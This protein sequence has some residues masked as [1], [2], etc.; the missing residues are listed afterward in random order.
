VHVRRWTTGL[1]AAGVTTA[2]LAG[3]SP[4]QAVQVA[5]KD[6]HPA[7]P[8]PVAPAKGSAPEQAPPFDDGGTSAAPTGPSVSVPV[9]GT[10][11]TTVLSGA[12]TQVGDLPV[13]VKGVKGSP[14]RVRVTLST[15]PDV[16]AQGGGAAVLVERLDGSRAPAPV[17]VALDASALGE[18]FHGNWVHRLRGQVV[19]ACVALTHPHA[20]HGKHKGHAYAYGL[21]RRCPDAQGVPPEPVPVTDD[22]GDGTVVFDMTA[23][24]EVTEEVQDPS[25]SPDPTASPDPSPTAPPTQAPSPFRAQARSVL[26]QAATATAPVTAM[27]LTSGASGSTGSFEATP[28][29]SSSHWQVGVQSGD[30]STSYS[31]PVPAAPAGSAPSLA[32]TYSSQSVDGRTSASNTQASWVGMGWDLDPGSVQRRYVPC[33]TSAHPGDLCWKS[34]N[35]V[36]SLGGSS[37][38]LYKGT[39]GRWHGASDSGWRV[40]ELTGAPNGTDT[41]QYWRVTDT[42]GTQYWFGYGQQPTTGRATGS[43]WT[44][45]VY[46]LHTGDPCH[47][48]SGSRCTQA[49][50]WNLDRVVDVHGNVTTYFWSPERNNYGRD[51]STTRLASYTRGGTLARV[52]YGQLAGHENVGAPAR[53][54]FSTAYR[55]DGL[56]VCPAPNEDNGK[57]FPD[58]PNDLLCPVDSRCTHHSP[59]FFDTRRLDKVTT[60][61]NARTAWRPVDEIALTHTFPATADTSDRTLFLSAIRR[62][63]IR[64]TTRTSLPPVR[65]SGIRLANRV[66]YQAAGVL[67]LNMWR[68]NRVLSEMGAL[69]MVSYGRPN[70][71]T[72]TALPKPAYNTSD[73][74]PQYWVPADNPRWAGFGWFHKYLVTKVVVRDQTGHAPDQVTAYLYGGHAAW[75]H[76]IDLFTPKSQQS[77]GQWRGYGVTTVT[78]GTAV[79][80]VSRSLWF[81]GMNGDPLPGSGTR[82]VSVTDSTGAAVTDGNWLAGQVRETRQLTPG[83]TELAGSVQSYFTKQTVVGTGFF[84]A[85]AVLPSRADT[86]TRIT[87]PLTG[88]LLPTRKTR[89]QVT[90]DPTYLQPTSALDQGDLATTTDDVCTSTT[91]VRNTTKWLLDTPSVVVTHPSTCASTTVLGKSEHLYD[92]Q[93]LGYAPKVGNETTTYVLVTA[94]HLARTDATYDGRGRVLSSTDANRHTSHITFTE[95]YPHGPVTTVTST[96]AKGFVR[97]SALD[98]WRQTPVTSTDQNGRSTTVRY[99]ALGRLVRVF[100]PGDSTSAT[101][102]GSRAIAYA[103]SQTSP[104]VVVTDVRQD[105]DTWVRGAAYVDSLGR[106][107]ETASPADGGRTFVY[108]RYDDRG[109]VAAVTNPLFST[110]DL[111]PGAL[112]GPMLVPAATSVDG[113]TRT[114]YDTLGRATATGLYTGAGVLQ[115]RTRTAYFGGSAVTTPPTGSVT[116]TYLDARG[117]TTRIEQPHGKHTIVT[118]YGYDRLG[119][120]LTVTDTARNVSSFA[121]D[122]LG[123][124]THQGMPDSGSTDTRYD[125]NGNVRHVTDATGA[126]VSTTYDVLN[127]PVRR[128][129]GDDHGAVLAAFGYDAPGYLGLLHTATRYDQGHPFIWSVDAYDD[130]NQPTQRTVSVPGSEGALAGSW[131]TK[132]GYDNL[133]QVHTVDL[134]AMADLPAETVTT[135]FDA[136]GR[137]DTLSGAASYVTGTGYDRLGRVSTRELGPVQRSYTYAPVTGRLSLLQATVGDAVVQADAFAYD[138]SGQLQHTHDGV[139]GQYQCNSYDDLHRLTHAWTTSVACT[140]GAGPD[141]VFGPA[142][143]DVRYALADAGQLLSMTSAGSASVAYSYPKAARAGAAVVRPHAVS[144][145]ADQHFGYF[146]TGELKTRTAGPDGPALGLSWTPEHTVATTT[147]VGVSDSYVYDPAGVRVLRRGADSS[148]LTVDGAELV[149]K[150]GQVTA[151][152]AY[153]Y[154]GV[155]VAVRTAAGV[156]WLLGDRQGSSS[157]T[158]TASG[159]VSRDRY[160]P[161][162]ATRTHEITLTDRGFLAKPHDAGTGLDVLDHRSYDP[163]LG[164]FASPD[165]VFQ[166]FTPAA[167]DTY[168]YASDNPTTSSDPTGLC[169]WCHFVQNAASGTVGAIKDA[170]VGTYE[171]VRH[172]S[173]ILDSYEAQCGTCSGWGGFFTVFN[174]FNP[175]AP[176]VNFAGN[177]ITGDNRGHVVHDLF[178]TATT[179]ALI[180]SPL[181]LRAPKLLT[182]LEPVANVTE[183]LQS[184][185]VKIP[186]PRLPVPR[187]VVHALDDSVAEDA[188]AGAAKAEQYVYRVH[189]GDSGPMGHSWTP[190][191]PMGMSNPR[192]ELG[193]PKGNS[194]QMLTRARVTDMEGVMQRDALPLDGNP[195]GAPEWLFPDPASQL[196]VHWTIP[197][198]PP[199]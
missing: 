11:D 185:A 89:T 5:R 102:K 54:S 20:S 130:R 176:T 13:R 31:I 122:L 160:R 162:G 174:S 88:A 49:W 96:D 180:V 190:E 26:P 56:A 106:T 173:R 75:H 181:K 132:V 28:L 193:L 65:F 91:Y 186:R 16:V 126:M 18:L 92:G 111:R 191:N 196:E 157:V 37:V 105:A 1:V 8:H 15:G 187:T 14:G 148:V 34:D 99:D 52:E 21:R 108:T 87:N 139:S 144:T 41:H 86:R 125:D 179:T 35:A 17:Q 123:R 113:Q 156:S 27:M 82:K 136:F 178:H 177:T 7:P 184:V 110:A 76:D 118:T 36:L 64:N 155:T 128:L 151:R 146:P 137:A 101:A 70:P 33:H 153:T 83:G 117:R 73:C 199:W 47:T 67:P 71:C 100:L 168:G 22:T 9:D 164:R 25:A 10:A 198:V 154:A 23:G 60:W 55:C 78:S 62:T 192:A 66:D 175:V 147:G 112:V 61:V 150:D 194:G 189:G 97:T 2:L 119:R 170:T 135:G 115:F 167:L 12:W 43:A 19:P 152:R 161:Y 46:G 165:P 50:R 124:Q 142:P 188:T 134:P 90:Y 133:G 77:W 63:G 127:R 195:G 159:Q 95:L 79:K 114:T 107:V 30:F 48:S 116:R 166:P 57:Y 143:Y 74:Y 85:W 104:S 158:V 120:L 145:V 53:V 29:S 109:Q 98:S 3:V 68:V 39:D 197:L 6:R 171:T 131:T 45:P 81:Q 163:V 103:V 84:S 40:Q 51:G 38:A 129:A 44:V 121:Y 32:L 72:A 172:P 182:N 80:S 169:D 93:P 69:T 141:R 94:K 138:N 4:A 24:E 149:L 59:T 140:D 183:K 42:A 58:V